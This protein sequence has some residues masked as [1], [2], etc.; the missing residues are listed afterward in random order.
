M[1]GTIIAQLINF[2]S[3]PILTRLYSP[4]AFGLFSLYS[5][6]L[7]TL[8]IIMAWRYDTAIN[9]AKGSRS[10]QYV[11]RMSVI[12][13]FVSLII[14]FPVLLVS[15]PFIS[16]LLNDRRIEDIIVLIAAG[17]FIYALNRT[18][19]F[20]L[21][22]QRNFKLIAFTRITYATVT[23]ISSLV[24]A[25]L[26]EIENG[27]IVGALV[28]VSTSVILILIFDNTR[29]KINFSKRRLETALYKYKDLPLKNMLPSLMAAVAIILPIFF[30]S[31]YYGIDN[32]G[33]FGLATKILLLPAA[34][35]AQAFSQYLFAEVSARY[36]TG[37]V[38]SHLILKVVVILSVISIPF[39][40]ILM[41]W[42]EPIFTFAFGSNWLM[43]G[44]IAQILGIAVAVRF[45]VG[46][47]SGTLIATFAIWKA[48]IWQVLYFFTTFTVLFV[49]GQIFE[50][51]TD[52]L[53]LYAVNEIILY[54]FYLFL[55]FSVRN[56]T[57]MA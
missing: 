40:S 41:L 25:L 49:G 53:M 42:G 36:R 20:W 51:L 7:T 39:V 11:L 54:L 28:G 38:F 35:V 19:N 4:E 21:T 24:F 29:K 14:L 2:A 23:V 34:I 27:L 8:G 45:I 32:A 48:S 37:K 52:F 6:F 13:I 47:V 1:M 33:Y 43:S 12:L 57:R 16:E 9:L 50:D 18:Y 3:S 15:K 56:K 22:R 46:C 31:S 44:T 10:A 17:I 30:I 55:I 5:G 26:I